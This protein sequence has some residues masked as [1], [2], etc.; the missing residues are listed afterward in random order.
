ME[1]APTHKMLSPVTPLTLLTLL[2][3][4][5]LLKCLHCFY[6]LHIGIHAYKPTYMPMWLEHF[7]NI[8]N[9]LGD[10]FCYKSVSDGWVDGSYLRMLQLHTKAPAVLKK[11]KH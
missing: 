5:T 9:G 8:T 4:L 3:L 10:F 11:Q 7:K 1:V 2:S 6:C